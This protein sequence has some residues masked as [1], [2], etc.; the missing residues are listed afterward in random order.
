MNSRLL[1]LF[2]C[3]ALAVPTRGRAETT[4]PEQR[5]EVTSVTYGLDVSFP[6][7]HR[8]STNYDVV[9]FENN[10]V[11]P[12]TDEPLQVLGN[13]QEMYLNHLNGCREKFSSTG[14]S[15]ACDSYEYDRMLMNRRQPQSMINMTEIGF[16]KVRAPEHLIILVEKFWQANHVIQTEENWGMGNSYYNYW[17]IPTTMVSVDDSGLRGSGAKL[18][19]EIWAALSAVME[20]WTQQELQPSSLYGV[21]VYGEGAVILPQYVTW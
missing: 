15:H 10:A 17:E 4:T 11:P 6:V 1:H 16:Q 21:R 2:L 14:D 18:K 5:Q 19:R 3:A 20:E 12:E 7:H 13:R 9:P 8:V